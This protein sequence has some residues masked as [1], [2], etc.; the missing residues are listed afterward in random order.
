MCAVLQT[1][2]ASSW[3]AVSGISLWVAQKPII[4]INIIVRC[5]YRV[6]FTHH[7]IYC[8]AVHMTESR[9]D[10]LNTIASIG[11]LHLNPVTNILI[12][13]HNTYIMYSTKTYVHACRYFSA[14]TYQTQLQIS[15]YVRLYYCFTT[16]KRRQV[17]GII[18]HSSAC[19]MITTFAH[20][21]ALGRVFLGQWVV[22][23]SA[24]AA[25]S[26]R[27]LTRTFE[28]RRGVSVISFFSVIDFYEP[29][30]IILDSEHTV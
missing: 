1:N 22:S 3:T 7:G 20:I 9:D 10:S 23:R 5:S 29:N 28:R 16:R 21:R 25:P 27:L 6:I 8:F 19:S 26:L 18:K 15:L 13:L 4:W 12:Y 2:V 17:L 11:L 14:L 30:W 24:D